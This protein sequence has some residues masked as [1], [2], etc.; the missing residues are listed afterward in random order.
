M[1]GIRSI[2]YN[3][4]EHCSEECFD[5]IQKI[6][7]KWQ[8]R[9]PL[10]RTSRL[11]MP[12][13]QN[14]NDLKQ[15]DVIADKCLKLGIRWFN[16][17]IDPWTVSNKGKA[18]SFAY[19][20]L[21]EFDRAFVHIIGVKDKKIDCDI[22]RK[23]G[24]LITN[25]SKLGSNG[26][27]NF[28][29]GISCNAV[30]N[31]PFFP[32]TMSSGEFSFSIALELTQEINQLIRKHT[33]MNMAELRD[34]IVLSLDEQIASIEKIALEFS[35]KYHI[36]FAGF[37]F[38]LAPI[39]EEDGSIWPILKHFGIHDFGKCGSMFVTYLLTDI[40]K[41]FGEKH[42]MVG[43]S[44]VMYSVLEDFELCRIN[45]EHT[46]N[47]EHLIAMS[48]MCGCGLDMIPIYSDTSN[49]QIVNLMLEIAAVSNR[50][51]KPLGIRLLPIPDTYKGNTY[52][53][54]FSEDAD[55]VANTKLV[56]LGKNIIK[57]GKM[58]E[59]NFLGK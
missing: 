48:T 39:I 16:I 4:P 24:E 19:N 6:N 15:L 26:H 22:L 53:T 44:G 57:L 51:N 43:F 50:L 34:I 23:S 49:N 56:D 21:K 9:Y 5:I 38:S 27:E 42:K 18:F 3:L 31:T 46:I 12:P 32:F 55:F 10:I 33:S 37:D 59:F 54:C 47:L 17:P 25:V 13:Q 41:S 2:T 29:L 36:S 28:R 30:A 11:N 1:I 20:V 7:V 52:H 58:K 14:C 8:T 45:N 35:E 40:L